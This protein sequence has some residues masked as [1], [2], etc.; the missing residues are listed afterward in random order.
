MSPSRSPFR[1]EG[2]AQGQSRGLILVERMDGNS[3]QGAEEAFGQDEGGE[4]A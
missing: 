1:Q 4:G 3:D 2:A